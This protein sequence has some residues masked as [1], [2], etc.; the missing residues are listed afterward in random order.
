LANIEELTGKAAMRAVMMM[1]Q[2][3]IN[4]A[5]GGIASLPPPCVVGGALST[6]SV[7]SASSG[8][9]PALELNMPV[10]HAPAL[11]PTIGAASRRPGW[12]TSTPVE[13]G[14]ARHQPQPHTVDRVRHPGRLEEA[15]SHVYC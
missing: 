2:E 10:A 5:F 6:S 4:V 14:K 7:T 1:K 15:S 11:A 12:A 8:C 3:A 9:P 13:V